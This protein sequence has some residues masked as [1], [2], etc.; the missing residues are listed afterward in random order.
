MV[1]HVGAGPPDSVVLPKGPADLWTP[2]VSGRVWF[3]VLVAVSVCVLAV[4]FVV[5]HRR[6]GTGRIGIR[7]VGT[8]A[9]MW[10]LPVLPAPPLL[11]LDA[12]SYLA[13]GTML[14]TGLDPYESGPDRL[15]GPLLAAVAPVWRATPAPYGPLSLGLLRMIVDWGGGSVAVSV[16]LLRAVALVAVAG[17]A[18]LAVQLATQAHAARTLDADADADAASD[19]RGAGPARAAA[20]ALV[21]ANPLVVL[22][23]V[24][25]V[26]LDALLTAL[27]ALTV[28]A[29]GHRVWI[30][31]GL[32]AAI[33]FTVKAT[34]AVLIAYVLSVR[35]R[36][37]GVFSRRTTGTGFLMTGAVVVLSALIPNGWGW[38]G[39]MDTPGLIRHP[40]DPA[41]V[42]GWLLHWAGALTP[43]TP[44]LARSVAIARVMLLA[45]GAVLVVRL[46][47]LPRRPARAGTALQVTALVAPTVHAWYLTWGLSLAGTTGRWAQQATVAVCVALCFTAMPETLSRRPAGI[48][49]TVALLVVA[50]AAVALPVLRAGWTGWT[51]RVARMTA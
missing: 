7:T 32:A 5:L 11:S 37:D 19:G 48:A 21:A 47:W 44:D 15:G 33:A 12:Y 43:W 6:A 31:A 14:L 51:D 18:L 38:L 20:L 27:A 8:A 16:F 26:H 3:A 45:G 35:A 46:L 25:G 23:L 9:V 4:T 42:V 24:G 17:S 2:A 49:L 1:G 22:H 30:V 39:A 34:G 29:A 13:Q 40:Y 50:L 10:T 36:T 41:T 28:F